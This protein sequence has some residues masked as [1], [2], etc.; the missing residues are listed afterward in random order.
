VVEESG[1]AKLKHRTL[2]PAAHREFQP[3]N[4]AWRRQQ[5]KQLI[6][7]AEA[8]P[9]HGVLFAKSYDTPMVKKPSA[10]IHSRKEEVTEGC[11]GDNPVASQLPFHFGCERESLSVGD[12]GR[13]RFMGEIMT[14]LFLAWKQ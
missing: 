14:W 11:R 9:P 12:T 3:E 1:R 4:K 6:K 10:K 5:G 7:G 8:S 2:Q 13:C